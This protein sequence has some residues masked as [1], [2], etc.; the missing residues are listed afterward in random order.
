MDGGHYEVGIAA[1]PGGPYTPA[2]VT[3]DRAAGGIDVEGLAPGRT[4]SLAVR[5][6]APARGEQAN[7]LTSPYGR[8]V[9]VTLPHLTVLPLVRR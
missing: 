3:A 8:E 9:S 4:H 1:E 5:A 6:H 2:G 7:A